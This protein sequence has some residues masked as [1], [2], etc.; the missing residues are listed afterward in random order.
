MK[1]SMLLLLLMTAVY[2]DV[3]VSA[4][5]G[6]VTIQIGGHSPK[7]LKSGSERKVECN[8]PIKVVDGKGVL[9]IS[10]D[11]RKIK[12]LHKKGSSF[13]PQ[14]HLCNSFWQN[15]Y[16]SGKEA[17]SAIIFTHENGVGGVS[18][19]IR[20]EGSVYLDI[21]VKRTDKNILLYSDQWGSLDIRLDLLRNGKVYKSMFFADPSADY[22]FFVIPATILKDH[23]TYKIVSN[24]NQPEYKGGEIL[25][26]SGKILF[27]K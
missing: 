1:K 2:A 26:Q 14:P 9:T 23:D 11:D 18:K 19:G 17:I 4:E 3:R 10:S 20:R 12:T 24:V 16:V 15:M 8:V 21:R 25:S 7:L 13:T 6:D 27:E 22:A 5:K